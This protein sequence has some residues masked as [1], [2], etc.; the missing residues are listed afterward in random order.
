MRLFGLRPAVSFIV[1]RFFTKTTFDPKELPDLPASANT[2]FAEGGDDIVNFYDFEDE[3]WYRVHT[4]NSDDDFI[5]NESI[6]VDILLVGGG[7]TSGFSTG[8]TTF[9]KGG[10]GGRVTFE[11][12]VSLTADTYPIVVGLGGASPT[13]AN[14][15]PGNDSEGLGFTADG[16]PGGTTASTGGAGGDG[17]GE[18]GAADGTGGRGVPI[19]FDFDL[20]IFY[21]GG[22]AGSK[23]PASSVSNGLGGL[24]GGAD[25]DNTSGIDGLGGGAG[26]RRSVSFEARGGHGIVK[27]RYK[28]D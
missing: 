7:G 26:M 2:V 20:P 21:G 11:E 8:T 18:N 19:K 28:L 13:T 16:A 23:A 25:D 24:D 9:Y 22:G 6:D 1:P 14:T 10:A 12:N 15:V 17:A 5:V 4:F 27:I 3:Q